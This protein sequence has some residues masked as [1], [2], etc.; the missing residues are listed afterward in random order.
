MLDEAGS[1]INDYSLESVLS[2][3]SFSFTFLDHSNPLAIAS[4][5]S[6]FKISPLLSGMEVLLIGRE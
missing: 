6:P 2:L 5:L 3:A 1:I 4:I